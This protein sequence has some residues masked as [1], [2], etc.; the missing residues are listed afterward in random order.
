MSHVGKVETQ[1]HGAIVSER[2]YSSLDT[3]LEI[4]DSGDCTYS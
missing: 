3:C 2:L 4:G 1:H